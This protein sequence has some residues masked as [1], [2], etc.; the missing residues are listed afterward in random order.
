MESILNDIVA[1]GI[2]EGPVIFQMTEKVVVQALRKGKTCKGN[3]C[4][5][6]E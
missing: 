1:M 2:E 6:K 5:G 4:K 3:L